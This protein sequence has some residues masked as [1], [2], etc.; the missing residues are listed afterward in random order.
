MD[1]EELE[2]FEIRTLR[3]EDAD[4]WGLVRMSTL[5]MAHHVN[6]RYERVLRI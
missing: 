3:Y 2:R 1:L 6:T 4:E 5:R